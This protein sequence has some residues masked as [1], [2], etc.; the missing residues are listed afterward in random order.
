M[1]RT[2][3]Q[4]RPFASPGARVL[5]APSTRSQR[6][7]T[8]SRWRLAGSRTTLARRSERVSFQSSF[9]QS[10]ALPMATSTTS[11]PWASKATRSRKRT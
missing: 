11:R 4:V 7:G 8:C 1:M 5:P 9:F 6:C 10:P 3:R 2:W